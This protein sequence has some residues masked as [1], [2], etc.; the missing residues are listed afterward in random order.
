MKFGKRLSSLIEEKRLNNL[1]LSKEIGNNTSDRLIGS[2]RKGEKHP[3][4]EKLILLADFFDVS[5]DYL[6]C[7]SDERAG[8][9]ESSPG[10]EIPDIEKAP[11][12]EISENG[13]KM[14]S[15]FEELSDRDQVLLIG[16]AIGLQ[17]AAQRD[18]Q[19]G[20]KHKAG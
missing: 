8:A 3:S 19:E 12:P 9:R 15:Y 18:Q 10:H 16:Q 17:L 6:C 4:F 20:K 11:A 7:R 2:W 13:R 1:A 14:L 5:L